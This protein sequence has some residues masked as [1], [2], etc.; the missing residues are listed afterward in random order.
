MHFDNIQLTITT[1][2]SILK[3]II[4]KIKILKKIFLTHQKTFFRLLKSNY[5]L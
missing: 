1:I 4:F 2:R 3:A 5:Y